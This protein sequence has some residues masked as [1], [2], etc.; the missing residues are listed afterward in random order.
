MLVYRESQAHKEL[1]VVLVMMA[2]Q[3]ILAYK[4]KEDLQD[5]Q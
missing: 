3:V 5:L 2:P 4:V 1:E